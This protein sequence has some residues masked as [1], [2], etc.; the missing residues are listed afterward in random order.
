MKI[1]LVFK[2][3]RECL[4]LKLSVAA[5]KFYIGIDIVVFSKMGDI[6][7]STEFIHMN[8][9]RLCIVENHDES[10]KILITA[11][12]RSKI[13]DLNLQVIFLICLHFEL[14]VLLVS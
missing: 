9:C 3:T 12:I 2:M 10:P 6:N 13:F 1:T 5:E 14:I 11:K 7:G 4:R 8:R